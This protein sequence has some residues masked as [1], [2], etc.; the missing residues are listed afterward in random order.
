MGTTRRGY[1]EIARALA[2]HTGGVDFDTHCVTHACDAS[3]SVRGFVLDLKALDS[4][5]PAALDLLRELIFELDPS[6]L[7]RLGE[8]TRES[9]AELQSR[10]RQA[11]SF[12]FGS[13]QAARG[14]SAEDRALDLVGGVPQLSLL[15]RFA[16]KGASREELLRGIEGVHAYL[17][18]CPFVTA[19]FTG[20]PAGA[21]LVRAALTDWLGA[22][23][24]H[25]PR[26]GRPGFQPW[27][28]PARE[29]LAC[30]IDVAHS[31]AV[32]PAP[33]ATHPDHALI[34]IGSH[35]V[36]FGYLLPEIRFKGNAYGAEAMYRRLRSSWTVFSFRDP[37]LANTLRVFDGILDH[38]RGAEWSEQD[39]HHAII[40]QA[41]LDQIP[42]RPEGATQL[43][44]YRHRYGLTPAIRR[45]RRERLLA[46]TASEVRRAMLEFLEPA[47][48][49]A[50][51]CVMAS[52]ER[53]EEANRELGAGALKIETLDI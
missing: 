38:V 22:L 28:Q 47:L 1:Q 14:W 10:A 7:E 12:L 33:H 43:A 52:R 44:L 20:T 26:A 17:L 25:A 30:A 35:L 34:Q 29:G 46:A 45:A 3:R 49:R 32:L 24:P 4:Q 50:S 13:S 2:A 41:K 42:I 5:L 31:A 21:K 39:V 48:P 23:G 15:G 37:H 51:V 16:E 36:K 11:G 19:S 40:A 9:H 27:S 18:A 53:L 6:D 8:V